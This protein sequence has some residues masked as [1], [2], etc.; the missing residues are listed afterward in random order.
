M[1]LKE[2]TNFL[3][4]WAPPSLQESY[5][6][7]GLIVGDPNVNIEKAIVSLDC[8]ESVV[9]EAIE[10]GAQMIIAHHPIVFGGIKRF[11]GQDYIQRT[12]MKAIKND[13]AIYAIH[14][15]L[16]NVPTGV[17]HHFANLLGLT[18]QQILVP[19]KDLLE[20]W[21]V[22]VPNTHADVVRD[23]M[24]QAGAG[25]IGAYAECSFNLEGKGTFKAGEN[26]NPHVGQQGER[27]TEEEQRVE[28]VVEKWRSSAVRKAMISSHP[29][30]EVAYDRYTL[31]NDH[32]NVGAGMVGELEKEMPFE[33]FLAFLKESLDLPVVKYTDQVKDTVKRVALCGGSGFSFLGSAMGS[34]ADVY[35]TSD[36]K[37]HQFFDAEGKISLMDIGHW[38]SERK[39]S[40]WIIDRLKQKFPTF[41]VHLSQINTN[42]V[43]YF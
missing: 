28:V 25:N 40:E 24:F 31:M 23:A 12:V 17:N 27:H 2:I 3:E 7:S 26:T 18:N 22:F 5:D 36:V 8:I 9:D 1:K 16:D 37:Y 34:G 35:I 11:T 6:N 29:Y 39:T 43:N 20:K 38:E 19:K 13:I 30:E 15:N 33:A 41:A 4:K 21:V 10:K 14:T 42:P 32:P